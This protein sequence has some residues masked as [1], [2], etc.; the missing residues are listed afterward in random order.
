MLKEPTAIDT[1]T[2]SLS[3]GLSNALNADSC[4][5]LSRVLRLVGTKNFKDKKNIRDVKLIE[6]ND[7]RYNLSAFEM[8]ESSADDYD[9]DKIVFSSKVQAIDIKDFKIKASVKKLIT[10]GFDALKYKSRSEA[11]YAVVCELVKENYRDDIILSIFENFAIGEKHREK[12]SLSYLKHS[13]AKARNLIA[14]P[15]ITCADTSAVEYAAIEDV[16]K[17]HYIFNQNTADISNLKIDDVRVLRVTTATV[18]ANM[19]KT[20]PLWLFIVTQPSGLKTEIIS[21]LDKIPQIYPISSLTPHT[22]ASGLRGVANAS[23]LPKLNHKIL[24]FKDFTSILTM[25]RENRAEILSQLREIY[26]GKY[27]K[28]F[29]SGISVDWKGKLGFIAG[30]TTVLDAHYSIYQV[31]GERFIQFRTVAPNPVKAALKSMQN[32][33]KEREI[34]EETSNT[35]AR[36]FKYLQLPAIEDIKISDEL[37]NKIARLAT[38]TVRARSGTIRNAFGGREIEYVPEPEGPARLAKQL[39]TLACALQI[40]SKTNEITE[41]DYALLYK[42]AQ[43]CI[44][45]HR[46][47][48]LKFLYSVKMYKKT[49]EVAVDIGYPTNTTRML[50]E[51][52]QSLS[53]I[54]KLSGGQ[55]KADSWKIAEDWLETLDI[56]EPK[57]EIQLASTVEEVKSDI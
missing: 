33:G 34:R 16:F 39:I 40:I 57:A 24:T 14:Q 1:S 20:D 30:V 15:T 19:L 29:G 45:K 52:M 13:I 3:K 42:V 37:S 18:I 53:L 49:S 43:D 38:Y 23:L 26:D 51:D 41:E 50:L 25:Q 10:E 32:R 27:K 9:I 2:K 28:D 54:E 17:K 35:M 44:Q 12:K 36:Y 55:G 22:F 6:I 31:L 7:R 5:D 11:D 48:V 8:F 21:A 46:N 47:S 4:F 56:I